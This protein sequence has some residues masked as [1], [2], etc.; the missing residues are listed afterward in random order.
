MHIKS[1]AKINLFLHVTGKRPDGY[2]NLL[3][4]MCGVSLYDDILLAPIPCPGIIVKCDHEAVPEDE[5]NL[6]YGAADLFFSKL[7]RPPAQ[8]VP[9]DRQGVRVYVPA[10]PVLE[11]A[12]IPH[13]PCPAGATAGGHAMRFV[14]AGLALSGSLLLAGCGRPLS[15]RTGLAHVVLYDFK[16]DA[17][18]DAREALCADAQALLSGLPTVRGM[19]LGTRT[20][21]L[22]SRFRAA[23]VRHVLLH[24][25]WATRVAARFA[26]LTIPYRDRT[27]VPSRFLDQRRSVA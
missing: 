10:P 8:G 24:P 25:R 9:A 3:S 6:A 13:G 20:G 14:T 19:W 21:W 27:S 5:T 16:P 4:L 26:M 15:Q 17:P 23:L 2:H 7:G 11:Q 22:G 12:G 18:P 1:P